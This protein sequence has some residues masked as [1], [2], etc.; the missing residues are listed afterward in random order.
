MLSAHD[1]PPGPIVRTRF[2]RQGRHEAAVRLLVATQPRDL[3][4]R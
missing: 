2:M 1:L 3:R 4:G